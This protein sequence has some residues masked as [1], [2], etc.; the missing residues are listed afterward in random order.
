MNLVIVCKRCARVGKAPRTPTGTR[1]SSTSIR[2]F[3][4]GVSPWSL[5]TPRRR[6]WSVSS[7]TLVRNGNRRG[8]PKP[9]WCIFPQDSAGKAIPYGVY[10][11]GHNE[12][13]V[14]VGCDHDTRAFAVAS[15]TELGKQRYP[16]ARDLFITAD[17][18]NGYLHAP[19]STDC[20]SSPMR[21]VCASTSAISRRAPARLSTA[22]CHITQNWRGKPT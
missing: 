18:G 15:L 12:A 7:R 16:D 5:S 1:S 14:N 2:P 3:C 10:D 6:S 4:N 8:G 21:R 9:H 11:M 17:A 13:W 20:S 19:G 22:C